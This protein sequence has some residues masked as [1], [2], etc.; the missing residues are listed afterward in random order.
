MK[1]ILVTAIGC[2]LFIAGQSAAAG[3]PELQARGATLFASPQLG[4]TGTSCTSCHPD[5]RRL[6]GAIDATDSELA[7]TINQ[8]IAGPLKG[9]AIAPD[10]I[11]MKALMLQVRALA[12]QAK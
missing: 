9:K 11:E 3:D 10:S 2:A 6:Q 7:T 12:N 8:C 1:A 4:T 5:G